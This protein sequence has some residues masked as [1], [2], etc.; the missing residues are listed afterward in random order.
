MVLDSLSFEAARIEYKTRIGNAKC[1]Q[2]SILR[3]R[4]LNSLQEP[5]EMRAVGT[6]EPMME[7]YRSRHAVILTWS[8]WP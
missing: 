4:A 1:D 8:S 7:D 5:I 3:I 6:R 2:N